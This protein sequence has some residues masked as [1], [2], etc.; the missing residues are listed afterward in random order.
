M[1]RSVWVAAFRRGGW[2]MKS[3]LE[4]SAEACHN[5]MP[6]DGMDGRGF[7]GEPSVP[8]KA[9]CLLELG[10]RDRFVPRVVA[11]PGPWEESR[12]GEWQG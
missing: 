9:G 2:R 10:A 7:V 3:L 8:S 12:A 11:L 6:A 1:V 5:A 4:R